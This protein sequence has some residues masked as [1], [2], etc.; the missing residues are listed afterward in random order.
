MGRDDVREL[1]LMITGAAF[2]STGATFYTASGPAP[3]LVVT[4]GFSA[5]IVGIVLLVAGIVGY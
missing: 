1:K 3:A 2:M 4:I 5:L